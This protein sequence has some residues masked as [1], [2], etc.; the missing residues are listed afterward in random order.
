MELLHCRLSESNNVSRYAIHLPGFR[1]WKPFPIKAGKFFKAWSYVA[2]INKVVKDI[3]FK[4]KSILELEIVT[5]EFPGKAR[6]HSLEREEQGFF[7][8]SSV[9]FR[10]IGHWV[11][12]RQVL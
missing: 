5:K 9:K 12:P 4:A 7:A 10:T 2:T 1:C 11:G 3:R 8:K 6:R